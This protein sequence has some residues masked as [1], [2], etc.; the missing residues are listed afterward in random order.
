MP[1]SFVT[2]SFGPSAYWTNEATVPECR[3]DPADG[4][5]VGCGPPITSLTRHGVLVIVIRLPVD[6]RTFRANTT[7]AGHPASVTSDSARS[8]PRQG[9]DLIAQVA[10]P[11][12]PSRNQIG[13]LRLEAYFGD[14]ADEGEMRAVLAGARPA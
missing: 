2:A 12:H 10:L 9:A 1:V 6:R 13:T 5:Y 11:D 3:P 4:D 14:P 7:I 8:Y